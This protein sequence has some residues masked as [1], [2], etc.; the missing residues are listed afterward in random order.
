MKKFLLTV[1]IGAIIF[2]LSALGLIVFGNSLNW[3]IFWGLLFVLGLAGKFL[4][5]IIPG[6]L[7]DWLARK[8]IFLSIL[9]LVLIFLYLIQITSSNIAFTAIFLILVAQVWTHP[10]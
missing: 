3:S 10:E 2:V 9:V 6:P 5:E 7:T 1:F 4:S 8:K